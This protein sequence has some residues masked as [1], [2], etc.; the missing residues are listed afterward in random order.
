MRH[1]ILF[2]LLTLAV[3]GGQAADKPSPTIAAFNEAMAGDDSTVKKQALRA[4][5]GSDDVI[6]PL[7]IQALGDSQIG[8]LAL[9]ALRSRT[10]L[11]PPANKR[12]GGPGYP[13][14]PA[15]DS[16]GSWSG[17]LSERT[18]DL[19]QKKKDSEISAAKAAKDAPAPAKKK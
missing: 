16:A 8:D 14:Y 10:G 1:L 9:T 3:T 13:G 4:L 19:E 12:V 15:D 7:L 11:T 17:W 6:L 18:K 2:T 5:T